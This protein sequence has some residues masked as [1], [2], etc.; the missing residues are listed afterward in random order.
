MSETTLH[1]FAKSDDG[2]I[3]QARR[4]RA[5]HNQEGEHRSRARWQPEE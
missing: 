5:A 2:A 1:R 4:V 3:F